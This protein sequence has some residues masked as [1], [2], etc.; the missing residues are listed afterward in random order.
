MEK[1]KSWIVDHDDSNVFVILYI[2]LAVVLS[3]AISLFWLVIVVLIHFIFELIKQN[4]LKSGFKGVIIRSSWELLLDFGL[5]L[6]AFVIAI[7][8]DVIL[9]A[10][11]IGAGARAGVQSV[12]KAGARFAGWQ[13][14]LRGFLL[15][16]DDVAQ[17]SKFSKRDQNQKVE[18]EIVEYGGWKKDW[19]FGDKLTVIFT[20]LSF[21][22]IFV[23]PS[24]TEYSM[25]EVF[26]IISE[27]LHPFP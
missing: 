20:V 18:T 24:L 8:M 15:S 23:S 6:F 13:R 14:A 27:D 2:T 21:V 1:A 19:G 16:V 9:G 4:E 3:I 11:G 7:Y 5:I 26:R 17:L 10:A 22:L 12:S 25:G